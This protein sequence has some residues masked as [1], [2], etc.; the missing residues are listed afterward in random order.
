[1]LDCK[2]KWSK[3]A[4]QNFCSYVTQRFVFHNSVNSG[5][6]NLIILI[7]LWA[8][9]ICGPKSNTGLKQFQN[10]YRFYFSGLRVY[11][12]MQVTSGV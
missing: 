7:L 4:G 5:T 9:S 6:W 1:M 2:Q 12:R 3:S 10:S 11:F 8:T